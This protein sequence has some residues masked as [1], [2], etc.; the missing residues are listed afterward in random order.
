VLL[1][2]ILK[3]KTDSS[4]GKAGGEITPEAYTITNDQLMKLLEN[5]KYCPL[6]V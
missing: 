1:D 6:L 2:L 3:V 4:A 5:E